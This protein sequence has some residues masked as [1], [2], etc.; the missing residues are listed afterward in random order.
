M[1]NGGGLF[2]IGVIPPATELK[3]ENQPGGCPSKFGTVIGEQRNSPHH[4]L[5]IF[6]IFDRE[7]RLEF[8]KVFFSFVPSNNFVATEK[9]TVVNLDRAVYN[10]TMKIPFGQ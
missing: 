9:D 4:S 5:L 3:G 8:I 6:L 1:A 7:L 10:Y 2:H